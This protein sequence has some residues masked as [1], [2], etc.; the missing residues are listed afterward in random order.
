MELLAFYLASLGYDNPKD[1]DLRDDSSVRHLI[2][3]LRQAIGE[4]DEV[5]ATGLEVPV[6]EVDSLL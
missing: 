4:F 3:W 5:A 1:F 2:D 6:S